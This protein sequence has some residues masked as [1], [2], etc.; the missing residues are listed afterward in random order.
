MVQANNG[1]VREVASFS[2]GWLFA[3]C[4]L[5]GISG[6]VR[7]AAQ[8]IGASLSKMNRWPGIGLMPVFNGRPEARVDWAFQPR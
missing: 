5:F 2:G 4:L 8:R 1:G 6:F 7:Q 3:V